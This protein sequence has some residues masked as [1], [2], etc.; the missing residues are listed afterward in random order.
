MQT[1]VRLPLDF[2]IKDICENTP[3]WSESGK[4]SVDFLQQKATKFVS[5][6]NSLIQV[7]SK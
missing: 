3:K 4:S 5:I 1:Q 6:C 7:Y 2:E